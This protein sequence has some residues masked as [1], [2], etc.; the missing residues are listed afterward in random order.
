MIDLTHAMGITPQS[1]YAAFGSKADLYRETLEWYR[2]ELS[3]LSPEELAGPDVVGTLSRWLLAEARRFGDPATPPGCMISTALLGCAV[4][5]DPIAEIVAG[6]RNGTLSLLQVRLGR[7]KAGGELK[8]D[9]EPRDIARF[10]GA[11]IQGMS[12][13][14]RDGAKSKELISLAQLAVNELE[15]QRA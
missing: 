12:V 10:I 9:A 14:A 15:R 3:S 13:Q 4:E 11:I 6:L 2:V 1:L 8:A 5:N 7:A